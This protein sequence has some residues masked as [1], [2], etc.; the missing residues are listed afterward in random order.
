MNGWKKWI[1]SLAFRT[2][3]G[4]LALVLALGVPAAQAADSM[5][6]YLNQVVDWGIM[7]GDIAG[8]LNEN[9]AITRAEFVSMINRAFE[10]GR[11]HV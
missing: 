5:Q 8:N 4:L 9:A 2:C 6:S 11:A 10:I 7:R 1:R 3:A